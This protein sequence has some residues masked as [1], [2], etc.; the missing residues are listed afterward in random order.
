MSVSIQ[1]QGLWSTSRLPEFQSDSL[2]FTST[3]ISFLSVLDTVVLILFFLL[4]SKGNLFLNCLSYAYSFLF[5][6]IGRKVLELGLQRLNNLCE[7]LE[8]S[9]FCLYF[10]E[11]EPQHVSCV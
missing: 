11:L 1:D 9:Y 4:K 7:Y 10:F 5:L 3:D 8:L 2:S 6:M